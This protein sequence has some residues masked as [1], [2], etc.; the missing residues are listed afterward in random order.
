MRILKALARMLPLALFAFMLAG[1]ALAQFSLIEGEV[2]DRDGRPFPDVTIVF[3][4]DASGQTLETKTDKNGQF[5][6]NGLRLGIWSLTV[7]IKGQVAHERKVMVRLAGAEKQVIN[8][9][10]LI[11]KMGAE[12]AAERKKQEEE[13]TKFQ[14]LKAHFDAGRAA[15]EQ[16]TTARNEALKLPAADR[17]PLTEMMMQHSTTAISELETARQAAPWTGGGWAPSRTR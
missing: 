9:K 17:G 2:R 8:F 11:A 13:S 4:N 12:D 1:P 6:M 7:Q 14:G 15:L 3:K 16:A 5:V 10:D